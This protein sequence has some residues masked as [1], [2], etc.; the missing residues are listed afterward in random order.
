LALE[1][2]WGKLREVRL[3]LPALRNSSASSPNGQA[4]QLVAPEA[5]L[6]GASTEFSLPSASGYRFSPADGSAPIYV[7][8]KPPKPDQFPTDGNMVLGEEASRDDG[9]PAIIGSRWILH[10]G[11]RLIDSP[12]ARNN[13]LSSWRNSFNYVDEGTAGSAGIGLRRPQLGALHA[14]HSH[15]SVNGGV[16]TVV[17][18]T[19]TGK[20]ETMLATVISAC[21]QRI[22]VLVPTDALR[23]Q[24]S[25]KFL[26]LGILKDERSLVLNP[27]V[28]RPVVGVLKKIPKSIEEV[29]DLFSLCNVVVTP[30]A[31]AGGC[32]LEVR[33]KMAEMCS[34]LFIDEAHH[35]EAPSWKEF[36]SV[37]KERRIVQFT[38]TPFRED[39]R[40]LDGKL[41]YVYSL[42]QAQ[43]EGFFRQ[44]RFSGVYAFDL[45]IADLEI[46]R[47]VLD[48]LGQDTTGKHV[49]MARVSSTKR[50]DEVYELYKGLGQF[51]PVVRHSGLPRGACGFKG[52]LVERSF[53]DRHLC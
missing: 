51:N 41:I 40:P 33:S 31:L 37:F 25:E 5:V 28:E 10:P 26:S 30:S 3:Y 38:A 23:T 52:E 20:T 46:A 12:N 2:G 6:E 8:P 42:R 49:A 17:M 36:K 15:W 34:H 47:T 14:I 44:I 48:E 27:E 39:G 9:V 50:A 21:C 4:T 43:E 32:P 11:L 24:I 18:P 29:Q 16:A 53:S 7:F 1:A 19:G 13:A 35:A 45:R 22:L